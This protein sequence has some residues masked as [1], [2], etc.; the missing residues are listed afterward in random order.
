MIR[1]NRSILTERIYAK[2][3]PGLAARIGD[4]GKRAG[5]G[6]G[7]TAP[8][9]LFFPIG[10]GGLRLVGAQRRTGLDRCA[11]SPCDRFTTARARQSTSRIASIWSD[12]AL[13]RLF[14]GARRITPLSVALQRKPSEE[15][16]EADGAG[17]N[18]QDD[19]D[20]RRREGPE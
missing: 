11:A 14:K 6:F 3:K 10:I 20:V 13:I 2:A 15:E 19:P 9:P 17:R 16:D 8:V 4:T 7:V 5:A 18:H 12:Y 1:P